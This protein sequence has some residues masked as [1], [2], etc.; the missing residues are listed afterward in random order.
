MRQ[1][2]E[3]VQQNTL[4]IVQRQEKLMLARVAFQD[5]IAELTLA[6]GPA[7]ATSGAAAAKSM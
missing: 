6:E 4:E 1:I 5:G 7:V 3:K 2:S